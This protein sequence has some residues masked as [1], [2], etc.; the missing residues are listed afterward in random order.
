M[1]EEAL[2]G[3]FE[4]GPRRRLRL[5]VQRAGLAGDIR[6]LHRRV[7]I[8]VNDRE[9]AGIGVVDAGLLGREL[10]LDQLVFDTFI[11]KRTRR[12]ETERLQ[13]ARQHL[14]CR[15]ASVLDR[16][17]ELGARGEREILA[18]PE[19]EA[20]GVGEIVDRRGAGR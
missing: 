13:I 4:G 15:D 2:L 20:L 14:H 8:V 16:L 19:T 17:D 9:C 1:A 7:E 11:G 10:M 5:R 6:G 18:A 3:R 12:V